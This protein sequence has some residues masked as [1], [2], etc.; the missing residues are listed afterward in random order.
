MLDSDPED[1]PVVDPKTMIPQK[2]A[3]IHSVSRVDAI[4]MDQP[5]K[6]DARKDWG[7]LIGRMKTDAPK[8]ALKKVPHK[9]QKAPPV[10]KVYSDGS[11]DGA[12][13]R[14]AWLPREEWLA[15][16]KK[17]EEGDDGFDIRVHGYWITRN[18][19]LVYRCP[20]GRELPATGVDSF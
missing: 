1:E 5:I 6:K 11:S 15:Q 12:A 7:G 20:D 14:R 3:A 4:S 10:K 18:R 19:G 16:R 8:A 9:Q 17:K 2:P 13:V